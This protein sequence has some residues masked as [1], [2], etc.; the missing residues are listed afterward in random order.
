MGRRL[1]ARRENAESRALLR[2]TASYLAVFGVVIAALSALA[3]TFVA[4]TYRSI[5][6]PALDTPEGRAG[7]AAALRPVLAAIVT[8]D[9]LLL[10]AVGAASLVLARS[11]LSP[12][13]RA[14]E[15]EERFAADAAHELRTPLGAI[16]SMAENAEHDAGE[17]ARSVFAS[18]ARRALECGDLVGD[19][20]TLSRASAPEALEAETLDF[21]SVVQHVVRDA[22]AAP[23]SVAIEVSVSETIVTGDQRRLRQLVRNLLD[24]AL[25][26]AT[27]NVAVTLKASNGDAL[28]S[29]EDDGP[30]VPADAIPRLF[31]RFSKGSNSRGSGLGLAIC[32]WIASAHG[33]EI[34][35][36]GGSRF[37]VRLPLATPA[38][39]AAS[40]S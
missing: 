28:L 37:T 3:Y 23:S 7:F 39:A 31:E 9:A 21:A 4:N 2:L 16:A 8:A 24:N 18:I 11:A 26:H 36:G 22:A 15:R 14:R 10:L 25:A 20:L 17:P 40:F 33:G 34:V 32:R 5:V 6:A 35:F 30:G 29:V 13:R 19:L 12:L 1:Q 38:P 27:S